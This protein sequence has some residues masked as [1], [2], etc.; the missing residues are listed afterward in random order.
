MNDIQE[1]TFDIQVLKKG[2]FRINEQL[3]SEMIRTISHAYMHPD[4]VIDRRF[5]SSDCILLLRNNGK[6]AGFS[7]F[8][9]TKLEMYDR[10]QPTTYLGIMAASPMIQ[11]KGLILRV[12]DAML[13]EI[14]TELEDESVNDHGKT[15]VWCTTSSPAIIRIFRKYFV[16]VSPDENGNIRSEHRMLEKAMRSYLCGRETGQDDLPLVLREFLP[17]S[18]YAPAETDRLEILHRHHPGN[19]IKRLDIDH[20]RGDRLIL[21]GYL[22]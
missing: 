20:Q 15:P 12:M 4:K 3:R 11:G 1:I 14:R 13:E 5:A 10:I 19:L 7:T 8:C 9:H 16:K 22:R 2:D 18:A 21:I 6:L 17:A